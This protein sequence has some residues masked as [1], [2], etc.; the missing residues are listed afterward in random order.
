[1]PHAVL[2]EYLGAAPQ[3]WCS[4]LRL[5]ISVACVLG[6]PAI[7]KAQDESADS[8]KTRRAVKLALPFLE[9]EGVKWMNEKACASCHHVPF[10]LWS[11][12]EA[13]SRGIAVDEKK[14]I[15]WT[16]WTR[17]FSKTR[18][19]WFRF[20]NDFDHSLPAEVA[21]RLKPLSDKP[22][23]TEKGLGGGTRERSDAGRA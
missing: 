3:R 21:A 9:N 8:A 18:R 22:F 6:L 17:T 7:A 5:L 11:H 15:E 14:L 19:A 16:E 10:L 23:T 4:H 12:N 20:T 13:R 2:N 1:M